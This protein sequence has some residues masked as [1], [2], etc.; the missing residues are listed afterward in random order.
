MGGLSRAYYYS[1][2]FALWEAGRAQQIARRMEIDSALA[3]SDL[4]RLHV[5]SQGVDQLFG[6][7][8]S[9]P[10]GMALDAFGVGPSSVRD[11]SRMQEVRIT[12]QMAT[13]DAYRS[14]KL[15]DAIRTA[16]PLGRMAVT[17]I[18][19]DAAAAEQVRKLI[20]ERGGLGTSLAVS[21]PQTYWEQ[22]T[23][24]QGY[25]A[26]VPV[27]SD[28]GAQV[29]MR[30]RMTSINAQIAEV[31]RQRQFERAERVKDNDDIVFG[32]G[33]RAAAL[34]FGSPKDLAR[35]SLQ[36]TQDIELRDVIRNA[37][38]NLPQVQ[39][40]Q[41]KERQQLE[42]SLTRQQHVQD[43]DAGGQVIVSGFR[44]QRRFEEAGRAQILADAA[45]QM[46]QHVGDKDAMDN[47][48]KVAEARMAEF[49]ANTAFERG[50]Q[51]LEI[52]GQTE[53]N[54][55]LLSRDSLGAQLARVKTQR[56]LAL[57][58]IPL[59]PSHAQQVVETQD[60]FDTIEALTQQQFGDTTQDIK[61]RLSYQRTGLE[62]LLGRSPLAASATAL[63]GQ[64]EQTI[65]DLMRSDRPEEAA[66]ARMNLRLALQFEKQQIFDR[67]RAVEGNAPNMA[68]GVEANGQQ[69]I[70]TAVKTIEGLLQRIVD[71]EFGGLAN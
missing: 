66:D 55:L 22:F 63:A 57:N 65:R 54:R 59:G 56:K 34:I 40:A 8:F 38:Q 28:E 21:R 39:A 15:A 1:I 26:R 2:V 53:A 33:L 64:G 27:I 23:D 44:A 18:R 60:M 70:A 6:G 20:E 42:Y 3:G 68:F 7:V 58:A 5:T 61:S 19:A 36:D 43:L 45:V 37:P 14:V 62:F 51:S 69:D 30:N 47:I 11:L 31:E 13:S 49:N 50:Q 10:F 4:E 46:A 24:Y 9:Q 41:V 17:D 12:N 52:T 25:N 67:Y 29:A 35:Q 48:T 71:K 32:Y 16:T